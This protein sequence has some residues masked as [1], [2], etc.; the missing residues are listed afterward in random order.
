MQEEFMT[1]DDLTVESLKSVFDAAMMETKTDDSGQLLV[2]D[3]T[4]WCNVYPF[5]EAH[6]VQLVMAYSIEDGPYDLLPFVNDANSGYIMIRAT[7]RDS[8]LVYFDHDIGI[9]G[10]V[11][12]KTFLF[13]VKRFLAIPPLVIAQELPKYKIEVTPLK[14][15]EF[16]R[17]GG[18]MLSSRRDPGLL[19][20]LSRHIT[21]R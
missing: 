19:S 13:A 21:W 15:P 3:G 2:G 7:V 10:G 1:A 16:S 11:V 12:K 17:D 14:A 18:A 4:S 9:Q 6:R 5:K 20:P 8:K